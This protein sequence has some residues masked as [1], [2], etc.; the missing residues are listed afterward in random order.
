MILFSD[1]MPSISFGVPE[2]PYGLHVPHIHNAQASF[3]HFAKAQEVFKF[4]LSSF[5]FSRG[6]IECKDRCIALT[7]SHMDIA[8]W[9][10]FQIGLAMQMKLRVNYSG[11]YGETPGSCQRQWPVKWGLFVY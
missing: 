2:I 11:K 9:I 3:L 5:F 10:S 7:F 4:C 6:R 8:V 1:K